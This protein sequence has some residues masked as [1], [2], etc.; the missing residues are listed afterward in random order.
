MT[1]LGFGFSTPVVVSQPLQ[2]SQKAVTPELRKTCC[3]QRER[4]GTEMLGMEQTTTKIRKATWKVPIPQLLNKLSMK[5]AK[6]TKLM[7][8]IKLCKI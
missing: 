2:V 7:R 1:L 8:V 4:K 6:N 3:S 5:K